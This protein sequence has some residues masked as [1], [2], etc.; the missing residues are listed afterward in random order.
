M[1]DDRVLEQLKYEINDALSTIIFYCRR[2]VKS[3]NIVKNNIKIAK[4]A[5]KKF[6]NILN[7]FL[8]EDEAVKEIENILKSK[9]LGER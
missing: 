3:P 7:E 8:E 4:T 9:Y 5:I 2:G 1:I 6:E